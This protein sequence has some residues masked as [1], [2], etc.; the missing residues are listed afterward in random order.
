M[1]IRSDPWILCLKFKKIY[2]TSPEV[3]YERLRKRGRAE[4]AGVPMD[5]IKVRRLVSFIHLS[6]FLLLIL[7]EKIVVSKPNINTEKNGKQMPLLI[8][9]IC[10]TFPIQIF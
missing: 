7:L 1:R 5:F 4:E 8:F 3:A 9:C 10:F 2:R 6:P